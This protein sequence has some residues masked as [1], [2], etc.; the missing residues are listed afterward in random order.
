MLQSF[1]AA[2]ESTFKVGKSPQQES[3]EGLDALP[4]SNASYQYCPLADIHNTRLI[5]L[6]PSSRRNAPLIFRLQE[7][8]LEDAPPYVAI[9]YAWDGQRLDRKVTCD[10]K[11][12]CISANAEAALRRLR[13]RKDYGGHYYWLDAICIDQSSTIERN[14][15]VSQMRRIYENA[16]R[17]AAWLGQI[18][19]VTNWPGWDDAHAALLEE[20]SAPLD[21][22]LVRKGWREV[23]KKGYWK[24]I[25][26]IQEMWFAAS[27][28]IYA[29]DYAP[30]K[31]RSL[32]RIPK[33]ERMKIQRHLGV[34]ERGSLRVEN[35]I[36]TLLK[37][38]TSEPLDYIFGL[39][40]LYSIELMNVDIDYNRS[41][42][43][44][45]AQAA[46]EMIIHGGWTLLFIASH[47]EKRQDCP[48][49]V[50]DWSSQWKSEGIDI[51][52]DVPK[53]P[54]ADLAENAQANFSMNFRSVF[55]RGRRVSKVL[56]SSWMFSDNENA[57]N[58]SNNCRSS[59]LLDPWC[60]LK[61]W[62]DECDN[63]GHA[64]EWQ[65]HLVGLVGLLCWTNTGPFL[66]KSYKEVLDSMQQAA[67]LYDA[68]IT[69]Q[70]FD[71]D[72]GY[73]NI[74]ECMSQIRAWLAEKHFILIEGGLL[75]V[76]QLS[77]PVEPGDEL[78]VFDALPDH[79]F[80]LR[81]V[82]FR[83]GLCHELVGWVRPERSLSSAALQRT[84]ELV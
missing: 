73:V 10:D 41:I 81:S 24:R 38:Y 31:A 77:C 42:G 49:W 25:W 62:A 22:D 3:S 6:Q 57:P 18:D 68:G 5:K 56:L 23:T 72:Y 45:Y 51:P 1:R 44:V 78:V 36:Q 19:S 52:L 55:L 14:H 8:A 20:S 21:P 47:R 59:C 30:I 50:P 82:S 16:Q 13:P 70:D 66:E 58:H 11:I 63:F 37:N 32:L 34:F 43:D 60:L 71:G 39:K 75:A 76:A 46:C 28:D 40:S 33:V 27:C 74:R 69:I 79:I 15:Q 7:V 80:A 61:R 83:G 12:M 29:G 48:S 53:M 64:G 65:A 67:R 84:F 26:T 4:H 17:V 54:N 2:I 9:S 35:L